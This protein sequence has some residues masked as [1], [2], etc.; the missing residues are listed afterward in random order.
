MI[1]SR[2]FSQMG[3]SKS[4]QPVVEADTQLAFVAPEFYAGMEL[5]NLE[6]RAARGQ[7]SGVILDRK[8]ELVEAI[9]GALVQGIGVDRI[10]KAFKV[11]VHSVLKL[12]ERRPE[13]MAREKQALSRLLGDI[14]TL[15]WE[16][17]R[18]A[19]INGEISAGQLPVGLGIA[20]DKKALLDGEVTSRVETVSR[21]EMTIE[22][23]MQ[24]AQRVR[25][26]QAKT[27]MVDLESEGLIE[28]GQ[29]N[30]RN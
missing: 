27:I 9:C 26:K 17:Y 22:D 25:E 2:R 7:F 16:R 30:E 11:S 14:Q 1:F 3:K 15:G 29:L 19:L 4:L 24:L 6:E 23:L 13:V 12:R 21:R 5:V 28:K 18:E 20:G 10:A 8:R